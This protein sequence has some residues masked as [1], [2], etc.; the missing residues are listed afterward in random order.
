M[1]VRVDYYANDAPVQSG[2]TG[3]FT[4][5]FSF[6]E[7]NAPKDDEWRKNFIRNCI[8]KFTGFSRIA[9]ITAKIVDE[10]KNDIQK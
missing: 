4:S 3:F 7:K 9:V 5:T 6:D 10:N 1:K 2:P 8:K